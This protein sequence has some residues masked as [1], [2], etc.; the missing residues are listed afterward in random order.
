[1][2]SWELSKT[3][4]SRWERLAISWALRT[5]FCIYQGTSSHGRNV[6]ERGWDPLLFPGAHWAPGSTL[7]VLHPQGSWQHCQVS[8]SCSLRIRTR[9]PWFRPRF[10]SRLYTLPLCAILSSI[11]GILYPFKKC[12]C[13]GAG[14]RPMRNGRDGVLRTWKMGHQVAACAARILHVAFPTRLETLKV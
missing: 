14:H 6:Q 10:V 4:L 1:M 13:V 3:G 11:Q 7:K 5:Y 2:K 8:R 9:V 12:R